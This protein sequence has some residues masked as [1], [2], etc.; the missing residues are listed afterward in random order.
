VIYRDGN[1][2]I[3]LDSLYISE[4]PIAL[5]LLHQVVKA[6]YV[7][8]VLDFNSCTAALP[9]PILAICSQVM[10]LRLNQFEFELV[11]PRK[12]E[13][14]RHFI[15][16]N[17]AHLL[18]PENNAPSKFRG[19]TILPATQ[20]GDSAA[21]KTAV[22]RIVDGILGA[23]PDLDREGLAAL[24]WSVNEITDNVLVHSQS[25]V[26]GLVQMSMFQRTSKRI[27]YIVVDAGIGIPRTLRQGHPELSS[28][29]AALERAIRE[30]VTRDENLGQ[31]NGLHGSYQVCSHSNGFFHLQSG[32]AKLAFTS[33]QG[34]QVSTEKVPFEGTLVAAQINFSDPQLL[35]E[36]L[37]F[38][39]RVHVP[40]DFVEVHYEQSD[41]D[42]VRFSLK[43]AASSFG[44]RL[45]G[46]PVRNKLM[47][48]VRMCANQR[49]IVDCSDVPLVS[50]SF[51]D[52]VFG[53][54]F[55]ELGPMTFAQRLEF[56]NLSSIVRQLTDKAI[57][58]RMSKT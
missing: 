18:D 20:F 17:W 6:G 58:Q 29:T 13:L 56:L 28:D 11:L 42:E 24:E 12:P 40:M 52:E 39:G 57:A 46:T 30:G 22:D 3:F 9:A 49:I 25:P 8:A 7:D 35:G 51:A 37:K 23:T 14:A 16:A 26:G 31:G 45:A 4:L 2:I 44:S 15:N 47:N 41:C 34:L 48:L 19:F 32:S 53:K 10:K 55:M 54:L 38:G 27:E 43:S 21:Q 36:A 33:S 5:A 50:S 1:R